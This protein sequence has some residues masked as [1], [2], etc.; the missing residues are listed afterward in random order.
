MSSIVGSR[1]GDTKCN[2]LK[3]T[4]SQHFQEVDGINRVKLPNEFCRL[5]VQHSESFCL[6]RAPAMAGNAPLT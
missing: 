1:I 3:S 6:L 5:A 4:F 2:G